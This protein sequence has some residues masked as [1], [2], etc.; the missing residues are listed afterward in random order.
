MA[1]ESKLQK[2]VRMAMVGAG[3]YVLKVSL[4]N[5]AGH[6][7]LTCFLDSKTIFIEMKAEGKKPEPLQVIRHQRLTELGF[8]VYVIDTWE[9]FLEMK[10][11]LANL[12]F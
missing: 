10:D 3:W 4:C 11:D 1:E 12:G 8:R 5:M 2:R 7:D 6:P 9:K